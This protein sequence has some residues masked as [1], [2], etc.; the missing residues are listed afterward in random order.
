MMNISHAYSFEIALNIANVAASRTSR[1][2]ARLVDHVFYQAIPIKKSFVHDLEADD[3][4]AFFENV[5]RRG[6]H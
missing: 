2:L 6:W 4:S 3:F 1:I 5:D